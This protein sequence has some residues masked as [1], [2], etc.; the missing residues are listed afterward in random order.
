MDNHHAAKAQH[1]MAHKG[2]FAY[3]NKKVSAQDDFY[4]V[5]F[6]NMPLVELN[7]I[8]TAGA[9]SQKLAVTEVLI[10]REPHSTHTT[11]L[12]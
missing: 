12:F 6:P 5:Q 7:G 11:T 3:S 10:T 9:S 2:A 4:Q 8:Y 1:L